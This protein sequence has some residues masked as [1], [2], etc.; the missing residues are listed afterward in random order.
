MVEDFYSAILLDP[1]FAQDDI[2]YTAERVGPRIDL[3]VPGERRSKHSLSA[4][5]SHTT[6]ETL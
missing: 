5:D 2:V 6:R 1:Q 4:M 3:T